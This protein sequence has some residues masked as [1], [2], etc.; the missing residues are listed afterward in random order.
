M[1][2]FLIPGMNEAESSAYRKLIRERKKA[3]LQGAYG[4]RKK[5]YTP[6]QGGGRQGNQYDNRGQFKGNKSGQANHIDPNVVAA[7]T[8]A[9]QQQG[10]NPY[11][12]AGPSRNDHHGGNKGYNYQGGYRGSNFK[13]YQGGSNGGNNGSAPPS[14]NG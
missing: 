3:D 7:A 8:L 1:S 12:S 6:T 14:N 11:S 2:H 5:A 10:F 9:L 13:Q 4:G